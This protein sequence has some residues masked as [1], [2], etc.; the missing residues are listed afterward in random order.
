MGSILSTYTTTHYQALQD[1]EQQ[2]LLCFATFL[3]NRFHLKL[4]AHTFVRNS[5]FANMQT[6]VIGKYNLFSYSGRTAATL[7]QH[8]YHYC[9]MHVLVNYNIH[10]HRECLILRKVVEYKKFQTSSFKKVIAEHANRNMTSKKSKPASIRTFF[11]EWFYLYQRKVRP[12]STK[13]GSRLQRRTYKLRI[14]RPSHQFWQLNKK[15]V[16]LLQH[17]YDAEVQQKRYRTPTKTSSTQLLD[18]SQT[19]KWLLI[20]DF[21]DLR[22]S[23]LANDN[24][25]VRGPSG[26]N[27]ATNIEL[28]TKHARLK[29]TL[30]G[31][32]PATEKVP[33]LQLANKTPNATIFKAFQ[34]R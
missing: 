17:L 18:N 11:M 14:A 19:R 6:F 10:K 21:R 31:R 15:L 3:C 22:Q 12:S 32:R 28:I 23:S 25:I 9:Q 5:K 30:Q 34:F 8:N 1:T 16:G 26:T 7:C 33:R 29:S 2:V 24:V 4:Y 27:Q 20:L 13:F